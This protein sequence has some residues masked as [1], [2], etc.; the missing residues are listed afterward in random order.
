MLPRTCADDKASRSGHIC[1]HTLVRKRGPSNAGDQASKCQRKHQSDP[2]SDEPAQPD[3]VMRG[4]K[5][6]KK[7]GG[8]G[9]KGK[10]TWK[11]STQK[12]A[13]DANQPSPTKLTPAKR[14]LVE[15]GM[16][17]A[18]LERVR[19]ASA[20]HMP[21]PPAIVSARQ[22]CPDDTASAKEPRMGVDA[23]SNSSETSGEGGSGASRNSSNASDDDNDSA[24]SDSPEEEATHDKDDNESGDDNDNKEN[25]DNDNDKENGDDNDNGNTN[26]NNNNN[27]DER[28]NGDDTNSDTSSSSNSSNNDDGDSNGNARN[29]NTTNLTH[30]NTNAAHANDMIA[31]AST[32]VAYA[33]TTHANVEH[34]NVEH[35][36]AA[37]ANATN[38]NVTHANAITAHAVHVRVNPATPQR[39]RGSETLTTDLGTQLVMMDGLDP[40]RDQ[41]VDMDVEGSPP[42]LGSSRTMGGILRGKAL[43][44]ALNHADFPR[45][46]SGD[47]F[48]AE[49]AQVNYKVFAYLVYSD[50]VKLSV[51]PDPS[52]PANTI[53]HVLTIPPLESAVV[54]K[55]VANRLESVKE[56]HV[57]V[58]SNLSGAWQWN[59]LGRYEHALAD[60]E[61]LESNE[62]DE[63][64]ILFV[65]L[66]PL[67]LMFLVHRL[68]MPYLN[69]GP[70]SMSC[71][72][73]S[74]SH[75]RSRP[76]SP[77]DVSAPSGSKCSIDE[78]LLGRLKAAGLTVNESLCYDTNPT[79]QVM[80]QRYTHI[81]ELQG[82]INDMVAEHKWK[83]QF[84][85]Y[86]NKTEVI[87][88]FVAKTT[89]HN[90]Y[91]KVFPMVEG[92]EDMVAWLEGDPDAKS[93]L[94]LWGVTKSKYSIT[95]LV[96]WLKKQKGKKVGK[97]VTKSTAKSP[98]GLKE[99]EKIQGSQSGAGAGAGKGN[100]KGVK[101]KEVESEQAD[102]RKKSHKKKKVTASGDQVLWR[103]PT[104][105]TVSILHLFM[106]LQMLSP[107]MILL[108]LCPGAN[109]MQN[110]QKFPDISFKV[111][112]EFIAQ[113]FSSKITL[114][115]VLI[116]IELAPT[117][118][119]SPTFR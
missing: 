27:G 1:A 102:N 2:E 63:C 36:N 68:T 71:H 16:A 99:K 112:N 62:N 42:A 40:L 107:F 73:F 23:H 91:A 58:Q 85:K 84:G 7:G 67:R 59:L 88:L 90:S 95:D 56:G 101:Q 53:F 96:E 31:H 57:F 24:A 39:V 38:A 111:F 10:R 12:A 103:L 48:F 75:S 86:P 66:T 69:L 28:N 6:G 14:K 72:A 100:Q 65:L 80:Y 18:P 52:L 55:K 113:N 83:A 34:A 20:S 43:G 109:A 47:H 97:S 61:S 19:D 29:T 105:I 11:T 50:P 17:V 30:V 94:D 115:T 44:N 54:L 79:L 76:D 110:Q 25:G 4:M 118:A 74:E 5:V 22:C 60:N 51:I 98:K 3:V 81:Y 64:H 116:F 106:V 41:D 37:N 9:K 87:G 114:A 70:E 13:E 35:A 33:S 104:L 108:F 15:S 78:N 93:D 119:K 26:D 45:L 117:P 46:D 21:P 82:K 77:M 32:N 8:K 92:Y 89:W 49:S